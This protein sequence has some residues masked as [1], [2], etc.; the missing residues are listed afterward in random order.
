M[1][2]W[3]V[4]ISL[5]TIFFRIRNFTVINRVSNFFD[6]FLLVAF[7]LDIFQPALRAIAF[8]EEFF[9]VPLPKSFREQRARLDQICDYVTI[10]P[11]STVLVVL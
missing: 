9:V 2:L 7:G 5:C 6:E 11:L 1:S 3:I 8:G 4:F 10:S